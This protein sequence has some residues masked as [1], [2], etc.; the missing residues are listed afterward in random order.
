[1]KTRFPLIAAVILTLTVMTSVAQVFQNG[2]RKLEIEFVQQPPCPIAISTKSVTLDPDSNT[3]KEHIV[4]EIENKS[5]VGIR[6]YAMVSGGNLYPT[7]H[8][9]IFPT[10]ALE[11][12]KPTLRSVW[13]N[14]QGH[15]YFFFDYILY[16]DG[17]VC[18]TNNH[19]RA[20]QIEG[21]LQAHK[22]AISRLRELADDEPVSAKIIEELDRSLAPGFFSADKAGPPNEDTIKKMPQRAWEH[23][24]ARLRAMKDGGETVTALAKKLE[25]E[26]LAATV[27]KS[28]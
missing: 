12:G 2:D 25:A 20:V 3:D 27:S 28:R 15:Y 8:T 23:I 18:G 14:R 7:V 24:V 22:A 26:I 17:S 5:D 21:Y 4:L 6:A 10:V 11:P 16:V 13:P 1:M 19:R 9:W